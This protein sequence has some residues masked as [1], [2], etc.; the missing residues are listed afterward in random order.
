MLT[1]LILFNFSKIKSE[2][3]FRIS[4]YNSFN[5]EFSKS[6]PYNGKNDDII[7]IKEDPSNHYIKKVNISLPSN[8]KLKEEAFRNDFFI[9]Y[10]NSFANFCGINEKM[11]I[12]IYAKGQYTPVINQ[13]GDIKINIDNIIKNLDE[14]SDYKRLKIHRSVFNRNK[15]RKIKEKK[16][17]LAPKKSPNLFKT[18]QKK[19]NFSDDDIISLEENN[20]DNKS[21][22]NDTN[23]SEKNENKNKIIPSNSINNSNNESNGRDNDIDNKPRDKTLLNIKRKLKNISINKKKEDLI[24]IKIKNEPKD[25]L[26][27]SLENNPFENNRG[28]IQ[29]KAL[30]LSKDNL[31]KSSNQQDSS[32]FNK[33]NVFNFSSNAIKNLSNN[34]PKKDNSNFPIFTPLNNF[35]KNEN[36]GGNINYKL[37]QS[38]SLL[39]PFPLPHG[40]FHSLFS[41]NI[42]VNS[43]YNFNSLFNDTF[44]FRN[45]D[46]NEDEEAQNNN[47]NNNINEAFNPN[48][49]DKMLGNYEKKENK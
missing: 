7:T 46:I 44:N 43:P 49:K 40:G 38:N 8:E 35:D 3:V 32:N 24:R 48:N 25:Q 42:S 12:E 36:I 6:E 26:N 11:F 1:N 18:A 17:N 29:K 19:S 23:Y 5:Y 21:K 28:Y 14:F 22:S 30:I 20:L 13:M 4:E 27:I 16:G 31:F 10:D 45:S 2:Q 15:K 37:L 39:S 41:P 9:K 47:N 34:S 33:N